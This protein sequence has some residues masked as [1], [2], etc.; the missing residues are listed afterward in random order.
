MARRAH[1]VQVTVSM[2]VMS[3]GQGYRYLL[4]TVAAGDGDR[5]VTEPLTRYYQEK[6][7]PPGQWAGSGVAGL[8]SAT[9]RVGDEVTEEQLKRF[10]GAGQDPNSGAQLGRPYRSFAGMRDRV[11][12]RGR[13]LPATLSEEDRAA[14]LVAIENEENARQTRRAVAGFDFTASVPKSVSTLW[15]VADAGTQALIAQAHHDAV[16]DVLR[17]VEARVAMTRVGARGPR[18]AVAQVE[19]RGVIAV[20][21][22]HYDSRSSD[23]QLHTH[24]VIGNRAQAAHD[25]KWRSLDGRPLHA[26][27]VALSETYNALLAD[28]LTAI[29]GVGW[30]SRDR[31]RDRN[32]GWEISGIPEDLMRDFSTRS[33]DIDERHEQLRAEFVEAH[34]R[35]PGRVQIIKLRQQATLE[36]RPLKNSHSL[37]ELTARWRERATKTLGTDAT[38]WARQL[39]AAQEAT[40]LLHRDDLSSADLDAAGI[41]VL[42]GVGD[43]RSTW[44]RWNLWAEAARVTLPLRFATAQDRTAILDEIVDRAE[45]RSLRLTPPE[46]ASSPT[47]FRR[48]DGGSVFREKAGTIYSSTALLAAEDTLREWASE[49]TGPAL[50]ADVIQRSA[51]ARASAPLSREQHGAI[52]AIAAS[53][54]VLD[55]LVGPA[56]T[57]KTTTLG[58]LRRAWEAHQGEGT[59]AGVAPSSVAADVLA[60]DLGIPTDNTAKWLHEHRQTPARIAERDRLLEWVGAL[61]ARP[62]MARSWRGRIATMSPVL[63]DTLEER[64]RWDSPN[65]APRLTAAARRRIRVLDDGIQAWTLRQGDLMIVDEASL[66]GTM[67]LEAITRHAREVGAK[68]LLAG[69]W[70]QLSAIESGGAFGMLVRDRAAP[71]ELT[72]VHR[73]AHV[74]EKDASL[75][76]RMGDVEVLPTYA[77]HDRIHGGDLEDMLEAAYRAWHADRVAGVTT[78]LIAETGDT[79][80]ALNERARADRILADEV[81]ADGVTLAGGSQAGRGDEILTRRNDRRL[82]TGRSGWVKNGD[83]WV[84]MRHRRDGSLTVR[85][86]G[87][88][89]GGIVTL[90]SDYVAEHVELAYAI[91]GHRAQGITLDTGHCVVHSSAMTR[92]TF[93]V[94]MSR[95]R[96]RNTCYVATD[97][98]HLEEHQ[99]QP[100][101]MTALDVL[102]SVVRHVGA[103]RS[104]HETIIDEQEAAGSIAQIASEYETIAQRAQ[105]DRWIELLHRCSIPAP[106]IAQMIDSESFGVLTSILWRAEAA[107]QDIDVLLAAAIRSRP[108]TGSEDAGAVLTSRLRDALQESGNPRARGRGWIV[109]MVPQAVAGADAEMRLALQERESLMRRRGRALVDRALRNQERW[110]HEL[111]SPPYD[112]HSRRAWFT[113]AGTVAAY[114][115]R[116]G[117]DAPDAIDSGGSGDWTRLSDR[118]HARDARD[119]A[120]LLARGSSSTPEPAAP[121][122]RESP[123]SVW[124]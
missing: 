70:A 59:V 120:Q 67:A 48:P 84:V 14:A 31:G 56:G 3:A 105:H 87:R 80:S 27:V 100:E 26:S 37:Q 51:Q 75:G 15:A 99:K 77:A 98:P 90:P 53:G 21:F 83:R 39:I 63:A 124:S 25:G 33:L 62:W 16:G 101:E 10:L 34:G 68:V 111:G 123:G 76:L 44:R 43:R 88:S 121:A 32:P 57:G 92:E 108:L 103:E 113:L 7:T 46:L 66:V 49:M 9:T 61:S 41:E 86:V 94:S 79:V 30:E 78:A 82:R 28:K 64:T 36:T 5:D 71:P 23:P 40:R 104:A 6:G 81:S 85:R 52:A 47:P 97:Q 107:G 65:L 102:A 73:F 19:V 4:R 110:I 29:L 96:Q 109:G 114:R 58:G 69:D 119:R 72:T 89:H 42:A 54:R 17:L 50:P 91:T 18:G 8:P 45:S 122:T 24:V 74:W 13:K 35:Q 93:Y 116:Y 20:A 106:A 95:G 60:E 115:D 12:A 55:V 38:G 2:R 117:I 1:R 11:R 22:D 112:V 118:D